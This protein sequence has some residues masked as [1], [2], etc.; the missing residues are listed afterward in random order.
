MGGLWIRIWR[1][2]ES[3]RDNQGGKT[4]SKT[5][6]TNKRYS[7]AIMDAMQCKDHPDA[8]QI[9]VMHDI[10]YKGDYGI[11]CTICLD[12]RHVSASEQG[13]A[14][15][16]RRRADE[17][18]KH[19]IYRHCFRCDSMQEMYWESAR[20]ATDGIHECVQCGQRHDV[21]DE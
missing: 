1:C 20:G 21:A 11:R 14:R 17:D 9:L 3:R 8:D 15:W 6:K 19:V 18:P 10:P 13:I 12:T 7:A 5:Y 2:T 4:L 16:R